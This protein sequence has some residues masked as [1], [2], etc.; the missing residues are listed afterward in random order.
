MIYLLAPLLLIAF[1]FVA[2]KSRPASDAKGNG[3]GQNLDS[4]NKVNDEL[5]IGTYNVQSGKNSDGN[6]DISR[7]AK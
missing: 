1:Y 7:D 3:I 6:R 2:Y 5:I 4:T